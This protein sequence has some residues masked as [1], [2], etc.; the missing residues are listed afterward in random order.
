MKRYSN[1]MDVRWKHPFNAIIAGPSQCGKSEF[2]KQLI[3][4]RCEIIDTPIDEI[5]YCHPSGQTI[6]HTIGFSHSFE[7]IPELSSFNPKIPKIIILDDMMR[8]ANENVVDLFTKGSHHYNLSVIFIMQN[9]FNQGKGRRD[10][11]LNSHSFHFSF[12]IYY[13]KCC[14]QCFHSDWLTSSGL[15]LYNYF[16]VIAS[17][18]NK[19]MVKE[20]YRKFV[21]SVFVFRRCWF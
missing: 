1:E 9:I 12:L 6:D 17:F 20:S 4:D 14:L 19:V 13:N 16:S 21:I 11:S 7:G 3:K 10:I 2:I 15:S 18:D 5:I 8:E